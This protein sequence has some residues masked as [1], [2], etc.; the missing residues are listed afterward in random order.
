MDFFVNFYQN[1]RQNFDYLVKVFFIQVKSISLEPLT[2]V[3]AALVFLIEHN[4]LPLLL[5]SLSQSQQNAIQMVLS[6][7]VSYHFGEFVGLLIAI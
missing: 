2:V 1:D 3:V 5:Q 4:I 7:W 6:R